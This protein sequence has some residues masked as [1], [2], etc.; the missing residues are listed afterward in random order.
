MNRQDRALHAGGERHDVAVDLRVV[1]GL[2]DR[3][4]STR[5]DQAAAPA[6]TSAMVRKSLSRD[7]GRPSARG[8]CR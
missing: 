5:P 8:R 2:R 6:T 1:S 4:S 7:G 3:C